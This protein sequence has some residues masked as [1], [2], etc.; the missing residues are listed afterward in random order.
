MKAIITSL[1]V[2]VSLPSAA[3]DA[4]VNLLKVPVSF[5]GVDIE[6]SELFEIVG[7]NLKPTPNV[8]F[9]GDAGKQKVNR[10]RVKDVSLG[11]LFKVIESVADV[12]IEVIDESGASGNADPFAGGSTSKQLTSSGVIIVSS[13]TPKQPA[14]QPSS[15][16]TQ[17]QKP[18]PPK[19]SKIET[20]VV[21][22]AELTI[23]QEALI[24]A[25]VVTWDAVDVGLK[26]RAKISYHEPS[27]LLIVSGPKE[28]IENAQKTVGALLPSYRE[29]IEKKAARYPVP[30]Y[31]NSTDA[32][33]NRVP[34]TST[35]YRNTKTGTNLKL[36]L[37]QP[38]EAVRVDRNSYGHQSYEDVAPRPAP[39]VPRAIPLPGR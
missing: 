8:V 3:Q 23:P 9:K 15:I 27:K 17:V 22:L 28:A 11:S 36:T 10:L 14:V 19:S 6:V 35:L 26:N 4:P 18:T 5:D 37:P 30:H 7:M 31:P 24:D 29:L 13:K 34:S 32:L 33:L 12:E 2:A 25:I 21:S 16:F 38:K 20:E 39:A 1:L